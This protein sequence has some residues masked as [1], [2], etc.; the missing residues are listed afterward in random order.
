MRILYF[1]DTYSYG[2]MGIK[3]SL[4]E[5]MERQKNAIMFQDKSRIG[6]IL[7]IIGFYKPDQVWLVHSGLVLQPEVKE[8]IKVPVVGFGFSD[9][10]YFSPERFKSYDIYITNHF[11][12]WEKY[13]KGVIPMLYNPTAC[14]L[15]FHKSNGMVKDI[16]V[17]CIG[18][19]NHPRFKFAELR[20][21]I[22]NRLRDET[23]FVI[24]AYGKGWPDEHDNF[25]HI[26]GT[27]FL[28]VLNRSRIGLDIEEPESPIARRM[29]EYGACGIPCIT[30][31]RPEI[32]KAF[33]PGL[34][35]LTY[36][37]YTDLKDKLIYYLG[38]PMELEQ[39]G[40]RA[41]DR[42]L[43]EHDI[44]KRV[45]KLLGFLEGVTGCV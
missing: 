38:N 5:E 14:D 31:E 17:S 43:K 15:T 45:T 21:K 44:S 12:T 8:K 19:G 16:D 2:V 30:K 9:P 33:V 22:V 42:C 1:S 35:I 39:I 3:R 23:P 34:E 32:E 27:E 29:M 13:Y 37:D 4:Y 40:L 36:A 28:E 6:G 10:Y 24:H 7:G 18:L 25:W 20:I 11:E 26:E 41:R